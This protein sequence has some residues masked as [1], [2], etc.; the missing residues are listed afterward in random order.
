M[1]MTIEDLNATSQT[2]ESRRYAFTALASLLT[3]SGVMFTYDKPCY[4]DRELGLSIVILRSTPLNRLE[5]CIMTMG[6]IPIPEAGP[7]RVVMFPSVLEKETFK[8]EFTQYYETALAE[9]LEKWGPDFR[10]FR[11]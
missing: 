11:E 1:K 2:E 4:H 6:Y 3:R 7:V 10:I 9:L 5:R 8:S